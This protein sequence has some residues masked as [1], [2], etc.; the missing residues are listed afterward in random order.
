VRYKYQ[1]NEFGNIYIHLK[2]RKEAGDQLGILG[3][4]LLNH[5]DK[6]ITA[7]D[8]PPKAGVIF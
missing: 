7:T 6:N 2:A 3:S 4:I 8:Y 1:T 5:L